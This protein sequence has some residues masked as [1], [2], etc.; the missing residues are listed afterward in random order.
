M[1]EKNNRTIQRCLHS[2]CPKWQPTELWELVIFERPLFWTVLKLY[3]SFTSIRP[4]KLFITKRGFR[5]QIQT[6]TCPNQLIFL[7]N[8]GGGGV[9]R[10]FQVGSQKLP[11][12]AYN[13][14]FPEIHACIFAKLHRR[15]FTLSNLFI[16][17]VYCI[18]SCTNVYKHRLLIRM[19]GSSFLI[20][21]WQFRS[22]FATLWANDLCGKFIGE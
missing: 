9:G 6:L 3:Q 8:S 14:S 2:V 16:Y 17:T 5:L 19:K 20:L 21:K 12:I 15:C 10:I 11:S 1:Y 7:G 22:Y 13:T 18:L 4:L